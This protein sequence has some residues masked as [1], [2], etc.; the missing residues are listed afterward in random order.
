M[1][2]SKQVKPLVEPLVEPPWVEFLRRKGLYN[3]KDFSHVLRGVL[4][5]LYVVESD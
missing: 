4:S 5:G 1:P 3:P 2:R